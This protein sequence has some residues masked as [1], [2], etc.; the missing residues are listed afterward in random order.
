MR[1]SEQIQG[2]IDQLRAELIRVRLIERQDAPRASR[3]DLSRQL[4]VLAELAQQGADELAAQSWSRRQGAMHL[5]QSLGDWQLLWVLEGTPPDS[6]NARWSLRAVLLDAHRRVAWRSARVD[7]TAVVC[8]G[9]YVLNGH[10]AAS[11]ASAISAVGL[12]AR[13]A[14]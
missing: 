5:R 4:E 1:T 3:Q 6:W 9:D 11:V 13:S 10:D 14:A 12:L 7:C 8:E 2:Q